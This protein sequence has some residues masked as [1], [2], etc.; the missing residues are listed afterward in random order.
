MYISNIQLTS[1]RYLVDWDFDSFYFLQKSTDEV[2]TSKR[3]NQL[4]CY[5]DQYKRVSIKGRKVV[6]ELHTR[7]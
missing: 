7:R 5:T 1:K 2:S 3:H 6:M 4:W